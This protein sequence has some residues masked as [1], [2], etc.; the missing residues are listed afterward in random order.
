[1][2]MGEKEVIVKPSL[3]EKPVPQSSDSRPCVHNNNLVIPASYLETGGVT[4][5]FEVRLS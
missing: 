5:I 3:F 1:M 4:A 2:G